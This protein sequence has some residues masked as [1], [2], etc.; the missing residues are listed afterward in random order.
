MRIDGYVAI[1]SLFNV[2]AGNIVDGAVNGDI[3]NAVILPSVT[4]S[5][6]DKL[7]EENIL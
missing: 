5:A 6:Y 1:N 2:Y 4:G 3:L 7:T